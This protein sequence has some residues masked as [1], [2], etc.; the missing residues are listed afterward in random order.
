MSADEGLALFNSSAQ[1]VA[2]LGG[3]YVLSVAAAGAS[4]LGRRL[5]PETHYV[6]CRWPVS[7]YPFLRQAIAWV[8][9]PAD[10]KKLAARPADWGP[11]VR[12]GRVA[13]LSPALARD[14]GLDTDGECVVTVY[15]DGK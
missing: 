11:N 7:R 1:M 8:E 3:E 2:Y 6:A 12:T 4:G 14:L 9:N 15:E 13:D 10:H 5:N